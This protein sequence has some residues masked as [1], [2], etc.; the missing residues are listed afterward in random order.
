MGIRLADKEHR[1]DP[2]VAT[3]R[4]AE[5]IQAYLAAVSFVDNQVGRMVDAIGKSPYADN[6]IIVLWSDHGYHF[7]E[8]FHFAK[9]TLW[10]ESA[11]M[12][13][14]IYAP[15]VTDGA[16]CDRPMDTIDIYP[17]LADLC[18]ITPPKDIDGISMVPLLRNPAMEWK[19]AVT[20]LQYTN[21]TVRS[22]DFRYIRYADGGEELYDHRIDPG[23][24]KNLAANPEY[25]STKEKLARHVPESFV[26]DALPY[27]FHKGYIP[28]HIR[29]EFE[30]TRSARQESWIPSDRYG[31]KK[32]K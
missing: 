10:E 2:V 25:K 15:G 23:E 20:M 19:P 3:G 22:D 17:T 11:R 28:P 29:N 13:C 6:T 31:E 4:V 16:N 14:I 5:V 12:P 1:Y 27:P 26:I 18:G 7:G 32:G 8:K 21:V 24:H 30:R 9:S